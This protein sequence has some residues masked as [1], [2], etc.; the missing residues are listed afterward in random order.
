MRLRSVGESFRATNVKRGAVCPLAATGGGPAPDVD[1]AWPATS[2]TAIAAMPQ[3]HFS[4]TRRSVPEVVDP[5]AVAPVGLPATDAD[6][7]ETVRAG[8]ERARYCRSDPHHVPGRELDDLAVELGTTGPGDHHIGLLLHAVP[9]TPG[10]SG[11]RFIGEPA[12][13]ELGRLQG[14]PRESP[15][16]LDILGADIA[17]FVE[18][19]LGPAGHCQTLAATG[20]GRSSSPAPGW[21]A[22]AARSSA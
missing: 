15:L 2:R 11:A 16:D 1:P 8:L 14:V 17:N 21:T 22:S 20:G 19:L 10:H 4:L 6:H 7:V 13:A 9:V 12:H 18:V 3:P 5:L